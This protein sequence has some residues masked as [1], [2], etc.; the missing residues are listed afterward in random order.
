[1]N[2]IKNIDT[3]LNSKEREWAELTLGC[4]KCDRAKKYFGIVTK[5]PATGLI[6]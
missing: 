5:N 2:K 3:V 1:M 4:R 6:V